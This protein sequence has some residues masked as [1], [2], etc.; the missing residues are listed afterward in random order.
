MKNGF[1][2]TDKIYIEYFFKLGYLIHCCNLISS[3]YNV[4]EGYANCLNKSLA[5]IKNSNMKKNILNFI[6]D[7]VVVDKITGGANG[8]A[9]GDTFSGKSNAADDCDVEPV[10]PIRLPDPIV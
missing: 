6:N 10:P 4:R 8:N 3:E 5:F 2:L 1:F 7:E 9:T